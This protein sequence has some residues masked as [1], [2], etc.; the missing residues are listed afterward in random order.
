MC[1]KYR[2]QS[3]DNKNYKTHKSLSKIH[4]GLPHYFTYLLQ[5]QNNSHLS[6]YKQPKWQY[7]IVAREMNSNFTKC[8]KYTIE[9]IEKHWKCSS[10]VKRIEGK[11]LK[12]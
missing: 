9:E 1:G 7:L 2:K 10:E 3:S 12:N 5:I 6:H 11:K 8:T 4:A